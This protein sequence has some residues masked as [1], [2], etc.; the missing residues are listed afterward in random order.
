MRNHMKIAFLLNT[1]ILFS[2]HSFAK[3]ECGSEY[4]TKSYNNSNNNYYYGDCP[5]IGTKEDLKQAIGDKA[6][7][8]ACV[9][10][11]EYSL[12][13]GGPISFTSEDYGNAYSC[14]FQNVDTNNKKEVVKF[15]DKDD[16]KKMHKACDTVIRQFAKDYNLTCK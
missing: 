3:S 8:T 15:A 7:P 9:S 5:C 1:V 14:F 10:D 16:I 11:S 2:I 4:N 6:I 13:I 12:L